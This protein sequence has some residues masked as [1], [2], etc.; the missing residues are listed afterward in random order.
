MKR[1]SI[2]GVG[3]GI[4]DIIVQ[5]EQALFDTFG[6]RSGSMQLVTSEDQAQ[7]LL[8][9]T[10]HR[11]NLVSGGAV[12][13]S[14]IIA[15]QL[16]AQAG[17]ICRLGD[18]RYGLH[19]QEELRSLGI[20]IPNPPI[21]RAASGT[22]AILV[23]PDGERTMSTCLQASADLSPEDVTEELIGESEWVFIEGYLLGNGEKGQGAV[24]KAIELAKKCDAKIALTFA[25]PFVVD[26]FRPLVREL[27]PSVDLVFA[28][29]E[30]ANTFAQTTSIEESIGTIAEVVRH[31]VV[32][33]G[34]NGVH[35]SKHG[36][37]I[38]VPAL[39][40][41]PVDLTG[42]GDAFAGGYLFGIT[43]NIEPEAAATGANA[44]AMHVIT[45][46]GARIQSGTKEYWD[47]A[48]SQR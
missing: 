9:L 23:T 27:L 25:A 43:R 34:A 2:C 47:N 19:Y 33:D 10:N 1:I 30:E 21:V 8:A 15:Q 3:N 29:H 20:E 36:R 18:D 14:I 11:L 6:L 7:L 17:F 42:A 12:C 28:N 46:I 41:T 35:I 37:R 5:V 38:H 39:S 44:L 40:C 32:T 16:G 22:S 13:N 24:K 31:V 4:T 45:R 48:L 26:I